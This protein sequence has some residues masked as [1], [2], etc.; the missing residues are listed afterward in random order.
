[1]CPFVPAPMRLWSGA[2]RDSHADLRCDKP[3]RVDCRPNGDNSMFDLIFQGAQAW[4]QVGFFIGALFLPWHRRPHPRQFIVLARARAARAGH[5]HRRDRQWRHL[6]AGVP[7]HF[8][9]RAKPYRKVGHQ[10]RLGA[11]Q[12]NRP[13][14]PVDDRPHNPEQACDAG[15]YLFDL[16]GLVFAGVGVLL[17]YVALTAFPVT[18][19][20]WIIAAAMSFILASAPIAFSFRRGSARPSRNG[21]S[22]ISGRRRSISPR[23]S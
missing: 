14:R 20:T 19:M 7:L 9:G 23:S 12:G 10:L 3:S 4:N 2:L 6:Y 15:S 13:R 8:G 5:R 17:G 11:R 22:S 21:G 18:R 1:M 16:V